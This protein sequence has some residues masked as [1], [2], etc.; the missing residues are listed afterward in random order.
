[1]M[2]VGDTV[3]LVAG[4]TGATT[5][6]GA[7]ANL[8]LGTMATQ[9]AGDYLP[10][11]GGTVFG[12]AGFTS[13]IYVRDVSYFGGG[14]SNALDKFRV[15]N[16]GTSV[17][18]D[19]VDAA[20]AVFKTMN[21]AAINYSFTGGGSLATDGPVRGT[22]Y[23]AY[24]G[25]FG[26][27]TGHVARGWNNGITRWLDVMESDG[28]F[29]LYSYDTA[30]GTP[31][32]VYNFKTPVAGGQALAT[33]SG[34]LTALGGLT[35]GAAVASTGA[36]S[37]LSFMER[38]D[39]SSKWDWYAQSGVARLWRSGYGD[40]VTV[41]A[42]GDVATVGSVDAGA[43]GANIGRAR[44]NVA[45]AGRTGFFSLYRS[46]GQRAGY[47]GYAGAGAD[48]IA[49]VPEDGIIGWRVDGD[50][51]HTNVVYMNNNLNMLWA[52]G[53]GYV[54]APRIFVGGGDPG[55][56]ASDGDIWIT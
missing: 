1:M 46:T 43:V 25:A 15:V 11:A 7:R 32:T 41:S 31:T 19:A 12:P 4:G 20:A 6:A 44:L 52:N 29:A 37:S 45:E 34:A 22:S 9:A 48:R 39:F 47:I 42:G 30:G 17:R 28:S 33:F 23:A 54:R 10:L 27:Q 51:L 21:F 36:A 50:M 16:A 8:G 14:P 2:P 56:A 5:A 38:N 18:L 53:A 40:R 26:V 55:A 3:P 35:S 13:S 24:G 49:M